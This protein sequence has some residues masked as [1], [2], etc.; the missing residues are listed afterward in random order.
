MGSSHV[1][2][3]AS[4]KGGVGKTTS[5]VNLAAGFAE[6]GRSVVVVD[7]DLGMANIRDVLDV[8][9][10]ATLHDVLAGDADL[11]AALLDGPDDLDAVVGTPSI[12]AFGRADT[13]GLSEIVETLRDRYD[14]VVLDTGAGLNYDAALPLGL[15]DEVILVTT[16]DDAALSNTVTTRDL[17]D[18][19]DGDLAGVIVNRMGGR[20]GSA[21]DDVEERLDAPV[22]GSVPEDSAVADT[23]A[24]GT[25]VVVANRTSPA[26]QSFREIAYGILDEPLP[27][28]WAD[29]ELSG[30]GGPAATTS[31]DTPVPGEQESDDVADESDF[32][33]A[34]EGPEGGVLDQGGDA[35]EGQE[36]PSAADSAASEAGDTADTSD[37]A[38][39]ETSDGPGL[40]DAIE[41]AESDPEAAERSPFGDAETDSGSDGDDT[42]ESRSLLSRVTG[43][44]F[45]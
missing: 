8:E 26:A 33:V 21:S 42:E 25:P 31:P 18:R 41:T 32:I 27:R 23:A 1:F 43:G 12:G 9:E 10:G 29:D 44:L 16:P 19:L 30:H 14:V 15:A 22:L 3:V 36:V 45:G 35:E 38:E 13:E 17:V 40:A 6:A 11:E 34:D 20:A 7:V 24:E 4:G 39:A 5:A 37:A 28:D 2:A